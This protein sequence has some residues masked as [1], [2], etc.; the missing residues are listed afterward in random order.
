MPV[1]GLTITITVC[2][3]S[4]QAAHTERIGV[5]I[6]GRMGLQ[7]NDKQAHWLAKVIAYC[8]GQADRQRTGEISTQGRDYRTQVR[9]DLLGKVPPLGLHP[10]GLE[11]SPDDPSGIDY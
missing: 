6:D 8:G 4:G 11:D 5:G 9:L 3:D 7:F 10:S 1:Q 2:C